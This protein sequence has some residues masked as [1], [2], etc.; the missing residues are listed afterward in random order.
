MA[1]RL[2]CHLGIAWLFGYL[3]RGVGSDA[4]S[5][6]ANWVYIYGTCLFVMYTGKMAVTLQ[7]EPRNRKIKIDN[8]LIF[9]ISVPLEIKNL[10]REHFNKWYSLGPYLISI[11]CIEIPFQVSVLMSK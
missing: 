6:L 10:T 1:V 11:F 5:A 9:C 3:Y 2:F 8:K 4:N 7:C